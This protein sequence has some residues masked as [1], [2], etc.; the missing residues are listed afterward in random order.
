MYLKSASPVK[1]LH[2]IFKGRFCCFS[3]E[4]VDDVDSWGESIEKL[5][6]CK[7]GQAAFQDFLKSEYS[8]E[9]ILF[10]LACE[11]Y[12]KISSAPEMI[13]RAN[14]IYTEF[15]Q[16][17]APRQ[18]NIDSGTRTNITNN[19]SEPNLSSF[20]TAQKMIFSLMARDCYPRFL[21]SDVYQS[22]LQKHGK[23]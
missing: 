6:S 7:A 19:I 10:W 22:I 20:D 13:S 3:Q 17:E 8:E 4:P 21:K 2:V 23:S 15:V 14:Q 11:E 12:K 18:V 5:L 1:D 16:T 9:N